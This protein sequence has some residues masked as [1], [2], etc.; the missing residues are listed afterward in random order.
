VAASGA[1]KYLAA[2]RLRS[3]ASLSVGVALV[4]T[5]CLACKDEGKGSAPKG[6]PPP[7]TSGASSSSG[8]SMGGGAGG[9]SACDPSA[10]GFVDTRTAAVLPSTVGAFCARKDA[11]AQA[12]GEGTGKDVKDIADAIDGAGDV[13]VRDF[14]AKR[15]EIVKYVDGKGTQAEVEVWVSTFDKPESA[16]GLY[17][18]R[19]VA[20]RDPDPDAAKAAGTRALKALKVQ[21]E[22]VLGNAQAFL[23]KGNDVVELTYD[24]DPSKTAEQ[25]TA[26]ADAILP[27]MSK[28]IGDKILGSTELPLDVRLL[29]TEAEGRIALG[30]DYVPPKYTRP[31]G[32][33]EALKITIPGGYA[34]AYMKENGKRYRVIAVARDEV[35]AARDAIS[36]F[37]KLPG[38][39]VMKIEKQT[40]DDAWTFPFS[41]GAGGPGAEGKAEGVVMRKGRIV[42]AVIDEEL[43][44]GDASK[45]DGWPRLSQEEKIMKL[46]A[47]LAVRSGPPG[48]MPVE[49]K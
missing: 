16:Y 21:G 49:A 31:E 27:E 25:A 34:L 19:V 24:A 10:V 15:F 22:S 36:S 13:Y 45:K 14:I 30:V 18:Y 38:A 6:T 46:K 9:S 7:S 48:P 3:V 5:A 40:A 11:E 23:W 44:L 32:K 39:V 35:D 4:A 47:L 28:A 41:V 26:E 37:Q 42:M 8:S 12:W 20:N 29:P 1:T 17:A 2:M 43:A 33:N